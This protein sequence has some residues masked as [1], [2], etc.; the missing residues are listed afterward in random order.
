MSFA[1]KGRQAVI[2]SARAGDRLRVMSVSKACRRCWNRSARDRLDLEAL[3]LGRELRQGIAPGL[4]L[5]P[6]VLGRPIA[7]RC[8]IR[9]SAAM[10]RRK[11]ATTSSRIALANSGHL[12]A[13]R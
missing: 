11:P 3:D 8:T 9:A 7:R 10:R 2:A 4:A 12:A 6:V 1:K 5:A 13:D